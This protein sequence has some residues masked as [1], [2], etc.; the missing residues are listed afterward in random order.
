MNRLEVLYCD[1]GTEGGVQSRGAGWHPAPL[2]RGP[3]VQRAKALIDRLSAGDL[4]RDVSS[5]GE[6]KHF[7]VRT[8]RGLAAIPSG[9]N[10]ALREVRTDRVSA[11]SLLYFREERLDWYENWEKTFAAEPLE[12]LLKGLPTPP[13]LL[14]VLVECAT[15]VSRLLPGDLTLRRAIRA[16]RRWAAGGGVLVTEDE[17]HEHLLL[18]ER[19]RKEYEAG[20]V[21]ITMGPIRPGGGSGYHR[22]LA[23]KAA[24][25]ACAALVGHLLRFRWRRGVSTNV[26]SRVVMAIRCNAIAEE[27][28]D[29]DGARRAVDASRSVTHLFRAR[30]TV[31]QFCLALAARIGA[32]QRGRRS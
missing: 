8:V 9:T 18:L 32:D 10:R 25:E 30:I 23:E 14:P 26:A 15:G 6:V 13:G 28:D 16:V 4:V 12:D 1:S 2:S 19:L 17:L 24:V 3:V 11:Q 21:A 22:L 7:W 27:R 31:S 20:R 5:E 29:Q